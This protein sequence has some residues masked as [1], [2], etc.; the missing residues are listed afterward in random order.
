MAPHVN[1]KNKKDNMYYRTQSTTMA[2]L[3]CEVKKSGAKKVCNTVFQKAGSLN[4]RSMS[5]DPCNQQQ[6]RSLKHRYHKQK[7]SDEIYSL[8]MQQKEHT[9]RPNGGFVCGLKFDGTP[10]YV[11]ANKSQLQDLNRFATNPIRFSYVGMDPTFRL[12]CFYVTPLVYKNLTL[13]KR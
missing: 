12:G 8:L 10:Q 5:E 11:L 7:D 13:V 3:K 1:R 6:A 2:A 9:S 4:S